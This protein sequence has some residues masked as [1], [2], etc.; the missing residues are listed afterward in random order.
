MSSFVRAAC[1]T[2]LAGVVAIPAAAGADPVPRLNVVLIVADDLGWADLGCY[3]SKYH[4]TPS[5]DRLAANGLRFTQ[6]YAA[7]PVCSPTRAAILTGKYPAR[8]GITD[9]LPGRPDRPDQKLLRPPLVTDLPASEL[10]LA[11]AFK[12]AGYTTGHIGKWHLGGAGAGPQDRGFDVNIAGDQTG[13][14][15]SYFAPYQGK[16]KR[17]MPGLETAPD[18][19]YLTDRLGAAAEKFLH[20]HKDK[21]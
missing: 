3:G 20:A 21:P 15:L 18:G 12:K 2:A 14:P 17:F 9:W 13:S 6:A 11:A 19:E 5:L 8:I 10:T 7:A 1:L 16:G 4:R